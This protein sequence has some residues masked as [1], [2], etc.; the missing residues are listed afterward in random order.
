MYDIIV[1]GGGPA[2]MTAALYAAR[3]GKSVLMLEKEAF[4]GQ[5]A[6]APRVE[7]FPSVTETAGAELAD[8]MFDQA[9]G[10]G[11]EFDMGTA[12]VEKREDGT[13]AVT[14][15]YGKYECRAVVLATG[16]SHKTLGLDGEKKLAG[17]GVCYCAVC[18]GAFYKDKKV[19]V[20]G[21]GN[22]AAQYALYLAEICSEVQLLTL[23]DRLFCDNELVVRIE[24]NDK[25]SW[26]KNVSVCDVVGDDKVQGVA[27][28]DNDGAVTYQDC[29][30]AFVAIGQE[31]HNKSFAGLV[32]LDERGYIVAAED[33]KTSCDGVFAAGDCRTKKVRQ[34]ATAVG[35]GAVAGFSASMYLDGLKK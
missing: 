24:K 17:K 4:G 30:A 11:V 14:T 3:A 32:A 1:I 28:K 23:F 34:C 7:N 18:D 2:G 22:S 29:D 8:K 26:I 21:D 27:Y 5:I 19:V 16:V 35:D 15:E 9:T 25:I 6:T 13:F 33:C 31:P 12:E 20:V 10:H